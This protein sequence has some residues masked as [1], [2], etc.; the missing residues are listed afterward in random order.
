MF[1]LLYSQFS[2]EQKIQGEIFIDLVGEK[3]VWELWISLLY[4]NKI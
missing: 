2:K 3:T 1:V 4:L